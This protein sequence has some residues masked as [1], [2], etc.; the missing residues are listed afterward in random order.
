[1]KKC[2]NC[3]QENPNTA[4]FCINCGVVLPEPKEKN[5]AAE[6]GS[7]P[8]CSSSVKAEAVKEDEQERNSKKDCS[9]FN[10]YYQSQTCGGSHG[11]PSVYPSDEQSRQTPTPDA[12]INSVS[13]QNRPLSTWEYFGYLLLFSVPLLGLICMIIF[14]TGAD[15]NKNLTN[16]SRAY[17]LIIVIFLLI[18]VLLIGCGAGAFLLLS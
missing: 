13:E 2:I 3:G 15:K 12:A 9:D 18:S 17:L 4:K 6:T 10:A 1:M 16:L 11:S 5:T 14:A 8:E 7:A